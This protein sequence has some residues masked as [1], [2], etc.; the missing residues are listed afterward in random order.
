MPTRLSKAQHRLREL[1]RDLDRARSALSSL[2]ARGDAPAMVETNKL[3]VRVH[4]VQIRAHCEEH[5]LPLPTNAGLDED[6]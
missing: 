4:E 1:L 5:G 3:N 6:E 2:E